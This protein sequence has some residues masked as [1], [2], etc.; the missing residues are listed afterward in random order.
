M[1]STGKQIK[2]A[3]GML[4]LTRRQLAVAAGVHENSIRYWETRAVP[5]GHRPYAIERI[6][7]ALAMLGVIAFADPYPGVRLSMVD[8]FDC[9]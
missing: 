1:I 2:A 3:R 6:E 5:S 4:G 9:P 8:N 7:Q